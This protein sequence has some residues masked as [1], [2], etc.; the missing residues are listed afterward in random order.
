MNLLTDYEGIFHLSCYKDCRYVI[1]PSHFHVRTRQKQ[2]I[3]LEMIFNLVNLIVKTSKFVQQWNSIHAH[4]QK[5]IGMPA[6]GCM[7]CYSLGICAYAKR[8]PVGK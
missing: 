5:G 3:P 2:N 7:Q 8:K 1:S 6:N 4:T